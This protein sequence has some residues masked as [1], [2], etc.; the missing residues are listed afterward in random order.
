MPKN[1]KTRTLAGLLTLGCLW[2][3]FGHA[4]SSKHTPKTTTG[5]REPV[6]HRSVAN[7][8]RLIDQHNQSLLQDRKH[9]E[10]IARHYLQN[11]DISETDFNWLKNTAADYQMEPQ[12]RG[13][14]TFFKD[15]L[16]RVDIVPASLALAQAMLE[17]GAGAAPLTRQSN[18]PFGIL[19]GKD[20][21]GKHDLKTFAGQQEA[22]AYYARLLNTAKAYQPFRELRAQA[23]SKNQKLRGEQLANGLGKYSTQ[24]KTY[25]QKVKTTITANHLAKLD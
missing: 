5:K 3:V 10:D 24:G 19:C 2:P 12:Q 21:P 9:I 13:D 1:L 22:V 7:L 11:D 4:D 18:N 17:S 16:L 14:Q 8:V 25:I 23:R 15:L 20:C 6:Q